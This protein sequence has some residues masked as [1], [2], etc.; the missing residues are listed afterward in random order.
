[1]RFELNYAKDEARS[2]IRVPYTYTDRPAV[3]LWEEWRN[4]H[5]DAE[6]SRW[7]NYIDFWMSGA[8]AFVFVS[9]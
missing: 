6:I 1:M 4:A 7:V 3:T 5:F 9:S 2:L 8:F